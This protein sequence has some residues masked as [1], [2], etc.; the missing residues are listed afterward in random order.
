MARGY[1]YGGYGGGYTTGTGAGIRRPYSYV[2]QYDPWADAAS[3]IGRAL[4]TLMEESATQAQRDRV[5]NRQ[6]IASLADIDADMEASQIDDRIATLAGLMDAEIDDTMLKKYGHALIGEMEGVK[7]IVENREAF[8]TSFDDTAAALDA[9]RER[10]LNKGDYSGASEAWDLYKKLYKSYSDNI[11]DFDAAQRKLYRDAFTQMDRE[12][13]VKTALEMLDVDK[14]ERGIQLDPD[15]YSPASQKWVDHAAFLDR[16]GQ[17][18]EA[19]RALYRIGA[20]E[21]KAAALRSSVEHS[22][23]VEAKRMVRNTYNEAYDHMKP[24]LSNVEKISRGGKVPLNVSPDVI[25]RQREEV[26]E[27]MMRFIQEEYALGKTL[28]HDT[29]TLDR[30]GNK[31][32]HDLRA[33]MTAWKDGSGTLP[34]VDA[35]EAMMAA[36]NIRYE[37]G[38][39]VMPAEEGYRPA[40]VDGKK[41]TSKHEKWTGSAWSREVKGDVIKIEAM[42]NMYELYIRLKEY[43]EFLR[44]SRSLYDQGRSPIEGILEGSVGEWES[45]P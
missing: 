8:E 9:L 4:N 12:F 14:E 32:T 34:T 42:Q 21:E 43:E 15:V 7:T 19:K 26:A 31:K 3:E 23:L 35:M 20:V 38:R 37:D 6:I 45:R 17:H 13:A 27:A 41:G 36:Y 40:M 16:T 18:T 44:G 39:V 10:A 28:M 22:N 5:F 1:G 11:S 24:I 33:I 30:Q 2:R 29:I 25:K